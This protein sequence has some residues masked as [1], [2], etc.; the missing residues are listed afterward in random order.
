MPTAID[1]ETTGL[2]PLTD[3]IRSIAVSAP[4]GWAVWESSDERRLL[5]DLLAWLLARPAGT[6]ISWNGSG[7]DFPFIATRAAAVNASIA[8]HLHLVE[9]PSRTPIYSPLDG[10][11]GGYLVQCAGWDHVDV[12]LPWRDV[13]HQAGRSG[14]LKSVAR[15]QG[16]DVI[17]VDRTQIDRLPHHELAA[18]NISDTEATLELALRLGDQADE[19]LDSVEWAGWT[20]P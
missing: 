5:N 17:E 13:A 16:L 4:D 19:W 8:Q 10:H 3:T 18:Y 7:F 6:L 20:L 12:M 9:V 1:I 14:G 2:S 15:W 11:T